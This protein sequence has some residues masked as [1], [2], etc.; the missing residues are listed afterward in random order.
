MW[1]KQPP[2]FLANLNN[3]QAFGSQNWFKHFKGIY[4]HRKPQL[5]KT[6][7]N[8][9]FASIFPLTKSGKCLPVHHQD[10]LGSFFPPRLR[11]PQV[12]EVA[13]VVEGEPFHHLHFMAFGLLSQPP[14]CFWFPIASH[15]YR[16][17]VFVKVNTLGGSPPR[18]RSGGRM[19]S[20]LS[21]WRR[22][23]PDLVLMVS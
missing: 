20:F 3:N 17:H 15:R 6:I 8:D 14:P 11:W 22:S 5:P 19:A 23:C 18:V 16:R 2:S 4:I 10:P 7:Q 12:L 9:W 13:P 21:C 1:K